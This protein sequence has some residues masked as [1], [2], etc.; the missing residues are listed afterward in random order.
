LIRPVSIA[1]AALLLGFPACRAKQAVGSS[2]ASLAVL[3]DEDVV[4]L[5]PHR[6]GGVFQTQTVLANMYEGL[7]AWTGS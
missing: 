5:D 6:V 3:N 4:G 7:V 2:S 1:M